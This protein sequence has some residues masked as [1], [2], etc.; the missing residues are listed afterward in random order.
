MLETREVPGEKPQQ[1]FQRAYVMI[2]LVPRHIRLVRQQKWVLF[3][4]SVNKI[5]R[6]AAAA[7][8]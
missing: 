5:E 3:S 4:L 2:R 6:T 8:Y 7:A 1:N